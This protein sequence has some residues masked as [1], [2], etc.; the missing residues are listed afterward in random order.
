MMN[1]A[2]A[3]FEQELCDGIAAEVAARASCPVVL[4][5]L[6][7]EPVQMGVQYGLLLSS[8]IGNESATIASSFLDVPLP[9]AVDENGLH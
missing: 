2:L 4:E 9:I 1:G 5:L 6:E 8:S 3:W 7:R